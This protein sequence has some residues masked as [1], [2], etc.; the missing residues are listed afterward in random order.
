MPF[1]VFIGRRSSKLLHVVRVFCHFLEDYIVP[2]LNEEGLVLLD[3]KVVIQHHEV[4]RW[5]RNVPLDI[6]IHGT[7]VVARIL[8]PVYSSVLGLQFVERLFDFLLS[9]QCFL[10][11]IFFLLYQCLFFLQFLFLE[12]F[13]LFLFRFLF[14]FSLF[15]KVNTTALH[16][17]G[18]DF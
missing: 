3:I 9:L 11:C 18:I 13:Q 14:L 8:C 6:S 4:G 15:F 2:M 12:L 1:D 10:L 16:L 17:L 5:G 7:N